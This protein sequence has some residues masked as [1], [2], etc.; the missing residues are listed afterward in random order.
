MRK[1]SFNFKKNNLLP[2]ILR[3]PCGFWAGSY[4]FS[5]FRKPSKIVEK[6]YRILPRISSKHSKKNNQI[7]LRKISFQ[8]EK[9]I[10]HF[11]KKNILSG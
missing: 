3:V 6:N 7:L 5:C 2:T 11:S 8:N 1:T 4:S 10:I 9:N